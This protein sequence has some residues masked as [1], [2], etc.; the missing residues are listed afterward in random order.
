MS[1]GV[2]YPALGQGGKEERNSIPRNIPLLSTVYTCPPAL[3]RLGKH[4]QREYYYEDTDY[5]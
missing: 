3:L 4:D 2:T 5:V 1:A